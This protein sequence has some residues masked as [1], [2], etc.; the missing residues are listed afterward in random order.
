MNLHFKV[1]TER[2]EALKW[3]WNFTVGARD[4]ESRWCGD[5]K[6]RFGYGGVKVQWE[7]A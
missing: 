6:R 1:Q 7:R 5:R 4:L 2:R 3:Q